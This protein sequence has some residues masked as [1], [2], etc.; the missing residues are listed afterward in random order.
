MF[1][2]YPQ[3]TQ[4]FKG[5]QTTHLQALAEGEMTFRFEGS[6]GVLSESLSDNCDAKIIGSWTEKQDHG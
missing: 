6:S 3:H 5:W 2:V 1:I 4:D